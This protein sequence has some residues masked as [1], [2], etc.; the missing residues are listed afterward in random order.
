MCG[1]VADS[2]TALRPAKPLLWKFKDKQDAKHDRH[3]DLQSLES[4]VG[5]FG[6]LIR[7]D[8]I[9]S[10]VDPCSRNQREDAC[11][12]KDRHRTVAPDRTEPGEKNDKNRGKKGGTE[13]PAASQQ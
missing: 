11:N 12:E 10:P 9:G 7:H 4:T 13:E 8:I 3:R 1:S 6:Q 5:S 2:R